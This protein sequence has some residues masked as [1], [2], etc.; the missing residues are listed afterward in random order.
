[1]AVAAI[2]FSVG[3]LVLTSAPAGAVIDPP[4]NC[5][6]QGTFEKGTKAR[7][8]FT[9]QADQIPAGRVV[10]VPRADTVTWSGSLPKLAAGGDPLTVT[11]PKRPIRGFVAVDLPWPF[12]SVTVDSWG[13]DSDVVGNK[14]EHTYD[15]PSVVPRGVEFKVFGEHRENGSVYCSGFVLVKIEGGPFDSPLIWASLG[16]T[17][18]SA[19]F[20]VVAGRPVFRKIWAY[21]DRKG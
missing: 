4:G 3:A 17:A 18:V 8:S 10:E 21:Q 16:L 14:G 9:E 2:S 7:G 20:F 15:L 1:M 12:G 5:V 19:A 6:G 13:N 11:V